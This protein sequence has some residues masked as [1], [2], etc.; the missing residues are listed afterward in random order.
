MATFFDKKNKSQQ[1]D[2]FQEGSNSKNTLPALSTLSQS[3]RST[4]KKYLN[5]NT[6]SVKSSGQNTQKYISTGKIRFEPMEP[7]VLLSADVNPAALTVAGSIDSPGEQDHFEFTLEATTRVVFD[8]LTDRNDINWRLS[9][10]T[11]EITESNF[12]NTGGSSSLGSAFE[13]I[14]GKY[15]LTVD[16]YKDAT[17]DYELRVIDASTA[18]VLTPGTEATATLDSGRKTAVYSFSATT[19]DKFFYDI[20]NTSGGNAYWRLIDPYGTQEIGV[21][22]ISSDAEAFTVQRT[23]VYLLLVEGDNNNTSPVSYSFNL[24]PV[25]DTTLPLALDTVTTANIDHAGKVS[26][27]TF[28]LSNNTPVLFEGL[29]DSDQ[30]SWS[31][32]GPDGQTVASRL[33][34][35]TSGFGFSEWQWLVPGDYRLTIDATL[36]T[37]GEAA[38]RLLTA[39]SST[40]LPLSTVTNAALDNARGMALF[41]VSLQEGDKLFMDGRSVDNGTVGWRLIDPYGD[42]VIASNTLN[43][44]VPAFTADITG[45]YWLVLEG[46]KSNDPA[47]TLTYEF[48]LNRVPDLI[49][50][51]DFNELISDAITVSGQTTVYEFDLA[52]PGRLVFDSLTETT[53][54]TWSLHGPRGTE[55]INQLFTSSDAVDGSAFFNLPAGTYQLKVHGTG[56]A[57]GAYS[58]QLLDSSVAPAIATDT[59]ISGTLTPGNS[60]NLYALTVEAGDQI[61]FDSI[62]IT[63]GSANWRLIDAYGRDV[64]GSN[65]LA[66]DKP[67]FV[68]DTAGTYSLLIEGSLV[69]TASVNYEFQFNYVSNIPQPQLP[70]GEAL[71][72]NDVIAGSLSATGESQV[73]RFTLDS[74]SVLIFDT[75]TNNSSFTWSM[76]GPL[77]QEVNNKRLYTSDAQYSDPTLALVKGEY[78]LTINAA[79][80][81][82][83]YAFRLINTADLAQIT[84]NQEISADRTPANETIGWRFDAK[85]GDVFTIP[86]NTTNSYWRVV[87]PFGKT[88]YTKYANNSN[89]SFT[90]TLDGTY[91]LLNEGF[92]YRSGT[93]NINF[94]LNQSNSIPGSLLFNDVINGQLAGSHEIHDFTFTLNE[95]QTIV[96]DSLESPSTRMNY[97]RWNLTGSGSTDILMSRWNPVTLEAG[98]YTL[99]V[100]TTNTQVDNYQFKVL[101]E[102]SASLLIPGTEVTGSLSPDNNVDI[103]KFSGI[104][105]ERFYFDS[106]DS[107]GSNW[108]LVD[109]YGNDVAS[110]NTRYDKDGVILE[111]TGEYLLT[112]YRDFRNDNANEYTYSF[113]L[114]P[115]ITTTAPFQLD[116]DI[117]NQLTQPNEQIKYNF[118]LTASIQVLV[119]SWNVDNDF[120]WSLSGPRGIE[121]ANRSFEDNNL[122]LDL[123]AGDYE[124]IVQA[125]NLTTGTFNFSLVDLSTATGINI[126]AP[127][128]ITADTG[129]RSYSRSFTLSSETE[130]V[131]DA[132]ELA[133]NSYTPWKIYDSRGNARFSGNMRYDSNR[134]TLSEGD[135]YLVVHGNNADTT[136]YD[137]VLREATTKQA[138]ILLDTFVNDSIAAGQ[139]AEYSF[140]LQDATTLLFDSITNNNDL[141]WRLD[142]PDGSVSSSDFTSA[143]NGNYTA[144]LNTN[145]G[146]LYTLTIASRTNLAADFGFK[147]HDLGSLVSQTLPENQTI[148][149]ETGNAS[150]LFAFDANIGDIFSFQASDITGGE[151]SVWLIGP[152]GYREVSVYDAARG[153]SREFTSEGTRVLVVQGALANT[154]PVEISFRSGFVQDRNLELVLDTENFSHIGTPNVNDHWSF[155]LDAPTQVLLDGLAGESINWQLYNTTVD[156]NFVSS[157]VLDSP[158]ILN[159]NAG[160]YLLSVNGGGS[161]DGVPGS[162]GVQLVDLSTTLT[163]EKDLPV[164]NN[165]SDTH[166]AK[167]YKLSTQA[168]DWLYLQATG[169]ENLPGRMTIFD[170]QGNLLTSISLPNAQYELAVGELATEYYIVID[171]EFNNTELLSYSLQVTSV[172]ETLSSASIGDFI[173]GEFTAPGEYHRYQISVADTTTFSI[174]NAETDNNI[175]WRLESVDGSIGNWQTWATYPVND[176]VQKINAGN[177]ILTISTTEV[178]GA[179]YRIQLTDFTSAPLLPTDGV[180][181]TLNNGRDT[182]AY[183][184]NLEQYQRI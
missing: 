117:T 108:K 14:S 165:I 141:T 67:S 62:A 79:Y 180:D 25:E 19:G 170:L 88:I 71:V 87:D 142:G 70:A 83:V 80:G 29:T 5:T 176:A 82:G 173:S 17:G 91:T 24:S 46:D 81:S 145:F 33:M 94:S 38:F 50:T 59:A 118:T 16:G 128:Q 10:P 178:N 148:T 119:D 8:S 167:I 61:S 175:R 120:N 114:L 28:S 162:Y 163:L 166:A 52:I 116:A 6:A 89:H 13:L 146:G 35:D 26:H 181:I 132:I 113:N 64:L 98:Q 101:N 21:T 160:T 92:Y 172:Q 122:V 58:F 100:S 95:P 156:T 54:I 34:T 102:S 69:N 74:N 60:T 11:G 20:N 49:S 84:L 147:L 76:V 149:L 39:A 90:T 97:I 93:E 115:L 159:L 85:S 55:V 136:T 15:E 157:G 121:A 77:G 51:L 140:V 161:S 127:V 75:Q 30:F 96:I 131:F 182:A 44:D 158:R 183:K 68:L 137:F 63:G 36:A 99:S 22:N 135:Y 48:A 104:A 40:N 124:F 109:A 41:N 43:S 126:D 139:V 57:T 45:N 171:S 2:N 112:V 23:G 31:L 86:N 144:T 174:N 134:F 47:L 12:Q 3:V 110:G 1:N 111:T 65:S 107:V 152:D 177:Y 153:F 37:T 133:N 129:D 164:T 154:S 53:D 179:N 143:E 78:A 7:R 4:F 151:V 73:Y 150:Q 66:L 32:E 27:Y 56:A 184:F 168:N 138:D 72:L 105:G 103:L 106:L 18:S 155:T 123:P 130:L 125:Y 9:G 42:H 169:F